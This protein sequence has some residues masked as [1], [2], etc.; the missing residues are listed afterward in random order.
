MFS[1]YQKRKKIPKTKIKTNQQN[2]NKTKPQQINKTKK[3]PN[4][5]KQQQKAPQKLWS[6]FCVGQEYS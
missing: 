4:K 2:K 6:V 1:F 5:I 3:N